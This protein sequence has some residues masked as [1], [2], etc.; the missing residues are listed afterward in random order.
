[1]G[2]AL[3]LNRGQAI[4]GPDVEHAAILEDGVNIGKDPYAVDA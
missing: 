2:A 1:M 4:Y 3:R